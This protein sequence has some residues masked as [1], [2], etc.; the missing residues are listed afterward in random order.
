MQ[1]IQKGP[2][3]FKSIEKVIA[4]NLIRFP[5]KPWQFTDEDNV[6]VDIHN[7]LYT[8]GTNQFLNVIS[9]FHA[10]FHVQNCPKLIY[11]IV[12]IWKEIPVSKQ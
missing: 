10:V 3:E 11:S 5:N 9:Y 1:A 8:K 7:S 6:A 2:N 4:N 12:N